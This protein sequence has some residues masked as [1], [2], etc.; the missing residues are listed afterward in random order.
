[1]LADLVIRDRIFGR[2]TVVGGWA[3][4]YG[5]KVRYEPDGERDASAP[6]WAERTEVP[7]PPMAS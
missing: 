3:A 6:S 7:Q 4:A 5:L 2:A 1:M